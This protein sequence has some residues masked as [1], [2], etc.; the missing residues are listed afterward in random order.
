M[1]LDTKF[2]IN[3]DGNTYERNFVVSRTAMIRLLSLRMIQGEQIRYTATTHHHAC[4]QSN[5]QLQRLRDIIISV[6][7]FFKIMK[8]NS[9]KEIL[10][11]SRKVSCY[12]GL[13]HPGIDNAA[14][15]LKKLHKFVTEPRHA[16]FELA[17]KAL[18]LLTWI[19]IVTVTYSSNHVHTI[20]ELA[21]LERY[22]YSKYI[23]NFIYFYL[24]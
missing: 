14:K 5:G 2:I 13:F 18:R 7:T 12:F 23:C 8:F 10:G 19:L 9:Y 16:V 4:C 22:N 21:L 15:I 17:P 6:C 11:T 20:I 3:R 24:F 1:L